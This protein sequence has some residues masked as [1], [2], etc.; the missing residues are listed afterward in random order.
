MQGIGLSAVGIGSVPRG[1]LCVSSG[2]GNSVNLVGKQRTPN[3]ADPKEAQHKTKNSELAR[4]KL[5]GGQLKCIIAKHIPHYTRPIDMHYRGTYPRRK[6]RGGVGDNL[7]TL[8]HAQVDRWACENPNV[9]TYNYPY[10]SADVTW[11][12]CWDELKGYVHTSVPAPIGKWG[13][14]HL[15]AHAK[16]RKSSN[17]GVLQTDQ[18]E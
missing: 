5:V 3:A 16:Y 9:Y 13:D 10:V 4:V 8:A 6:R 18:I 14:V 11:S 2:S 15:S 17:I 7:H 12:S 1:S